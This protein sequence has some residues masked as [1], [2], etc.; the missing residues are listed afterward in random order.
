MTF[1]FGQYY[2]TELHFNKPITVQVCMCSVYVDLFP[3]QTVHIVSQTFGTYS[4]VGVIGAWGI[5]N[6]V[7]VKQGYNEMPYKPKTSRH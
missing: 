2:A 3:T 6:F 7:P 4:S 1:V 5:A